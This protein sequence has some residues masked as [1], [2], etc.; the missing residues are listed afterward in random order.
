MNGFNFNILVKS[1][2]A[3]SPEG[4]MQNYARKNSRMSFGYDRNGRAYLDICGTRFYYSHWSAQ[5]V[6]SDTQLVIVYLV[7][8]NEG[9]KT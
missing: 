2:Q 9:G 6:S 1:S 5:P 3:F 4:L 8:D 7:E